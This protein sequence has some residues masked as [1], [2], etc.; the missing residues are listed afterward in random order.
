MK[1]KEFDEVKLKDGR[2]G[3]IMDMLGPDYIV[4]VGETE[5]DYETIMVKPEEIEGPA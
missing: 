5:K 4:D 3:T 1:Y 2:A